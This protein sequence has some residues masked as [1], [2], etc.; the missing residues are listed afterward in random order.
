MAL[1]GLPTHRCPAA[2]EESHV[3]GKHLCSTDK[4]R[5]DLSPWFRHPGSAA[6][7]IHGPLFRRENNLSDG[8]NFGLILLPYINDWGEAQAAIT[9]RKA[10]VTALKAFP[11]AADRSYCF[12]TARHFAPRNSALP[13]P[14]WT[15]LINVPPF[16]GWTWFA[17]PLKRWLEYAQ[18]KADALGAPDSL[19]AD[20]AVK[21]AIQWCHDVQQA[22]E[23]LSRERFPYSPPDL[24]RYWR[25]R[26]DLS[27]IPGVGGVPPDFRPTP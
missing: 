12:G 26:S 14:L 18:Q 22:F 2:H 27:L 1:E 21:N 24:V 9:M 20:V 11:R 23:T 17:G 5:T 19:L 16:V 3:P 8:F 6:A 25:A 7:S 15:Y 10:A 4:P 13:P